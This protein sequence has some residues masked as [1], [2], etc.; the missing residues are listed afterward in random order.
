MDSWD[1]RFF[2]PSQHITIEAAKRPDTIHILYYF[3]NP[4]VRIYQVILI[5]MQ[6][7]LDSDVSA[8]LGID[9]LYMENRIYPNTFGDQDFRQE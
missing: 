5:S 8:V 2:L 6:G 3:Y 1:G 4:N 9:S 7:V